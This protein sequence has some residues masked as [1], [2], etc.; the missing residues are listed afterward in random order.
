MR[1]LKHKIK[2]IA[3][4]WD[5]PV[6]NIISRMN[7][8]EYSMDINWVKKKCLRVS[9]RFMGK[10]LNWVKA[11]IPFSWKFQTYLFPDHILSLWCVVPVNVLYTCHFMWVNKIYIL[12]LVPFLKYTNTILKRYRMCCLFPTSS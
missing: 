7:L 2:D 10:S 3:R 4:L 5:R 9:L 11:Y 12:I 6:Y 8:M 1:R